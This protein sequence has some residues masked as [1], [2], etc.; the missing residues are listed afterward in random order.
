[1]EFDFLSMTLEVEAA[2]YFRV[3]VAAST[4]QKAGLVVYPLEN[5]GSGP[6][7]ADRLGERP[8][9]SREVA[10]QAQRVDG[11]TVGIASMVQRVDLAPGGFEATS[12]PI[13]WKRVR[14]LKIWGGYVRPGEEW[15]E[16][17]PE[18]VV[19]GGEGGVEREGWGL[20]NLVLRKRCE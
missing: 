9:P 12:L 4:G 14:W 18:E 5:H 1:M 2:R 16:W 19:A 13:G 11:N 10:S 3:W 8:I 20:D 15:G 6:G 17:V 7:D